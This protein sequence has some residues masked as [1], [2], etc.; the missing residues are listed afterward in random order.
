MLEDKQKVEHLNQELLSALEQLDKKNREIQ[1]LM[2]TDKLT[3][4]YNRNYLNTVY[5]DE[6][7]RCCRY[8]RPLALLM[9]DIDKFK[10]FNDSYGHLAGDEMLSWFGTLIKGYIRKFD[11]AFRYG[12]E[13]FLIIL[14]ETDMMLAYIVAERIRRGFEKKVFNVGRD[15]KTESASRT[16]SIGIT[17]TLSD[18]GIEKMINQADKALYLAKSQGGNM[19]IKYEENEKK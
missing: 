14:P 12:G 3:G 6:T 2:I 5:E 13:E 15:E 17:N 4:L 19:S 16:I 7:A 11:R 1:E 9:A 10:S 8:D 18:V